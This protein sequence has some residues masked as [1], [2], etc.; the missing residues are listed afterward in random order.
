MAMQGVMVT[1]ARCRGP[2]R[3][4]AEEPVGTGLVLD[5]RRRGD[6]VVKRREFIKRIGGAAAAWPL[7]ARA[8]QPDRMRRIGVAMARYRRASGTSGPACCARWR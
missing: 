1:C 5:P 3:L 8:Q 6:R 7:A 2:D 4:R